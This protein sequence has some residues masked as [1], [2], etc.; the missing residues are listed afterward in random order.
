MTDP[1]ECLFS[2]SFYSNLTLKLATKMTSQ[3]K[4]EIDPR[5]FDTF[6][7]LKCLSE[8][9]C[10]LKERLQRHLSTDV[11]S[12]NLDYSRARAYC[13]CSRCAWVC[14]DI[15]SYLSFLFFLTR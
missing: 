9:S 10:L 3:L 12:T 11:L 7:Q 14:L 8:K 5:E 4:V 15:F 1:S 13:A 6:I 2:H